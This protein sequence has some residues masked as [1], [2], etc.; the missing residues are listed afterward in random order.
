VLFRSGNE[1]DHD[2]CREVAQSPKIEVRKM[3]ESSLA[4]AYTPANCLSDKSICTQS[5]AP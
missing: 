3:L 1:I 2:N 4:N 5:S